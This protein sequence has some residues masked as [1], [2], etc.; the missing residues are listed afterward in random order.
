MRPCYY[1]DFTAPPGQRAKPYAV[2]QTFSQLHAVFSNVPE[3]FALAPVPPY[4]AAPQGFRVFASTQADLEMLTSLLGAAALPGGN[5]RQVPDDFSGRWLTFSRYRIPTRKQERHPEGNLRERRLRN[6]DE[7]QLQF[8]PVSSNSNRQ[9]FRLYIARTQGPQQR[10]ECVPNTYG[11][12][13]QTRWFTLPDVG[14]G[15]G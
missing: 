12:A 11:L 2:A 9:N 8:V 13:S 3:T 6:A 15:G 5:I 1:L 10:E 7:Q 14:I 4:E